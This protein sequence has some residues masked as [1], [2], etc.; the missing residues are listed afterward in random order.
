MRRA[1]FS[2][3]FLIVT[4][5]V[6]LG[7]VLDQFLQTYSPVPEVTQIE[8]D[9]LVVVEEYVRAVPP[10]QAQRAVQQLA[11]SLQSDI[12]LLPADDL[13]KSHLSRVIEGGDIAVVNTEEGDKLLYKAVP[14]VDQVLSLRRTK[15]ELTRPPI[16]DVLLIVFYGS[17]AVVVFFWVWPLSRDLRRLEKQTRLIGN[18]Q[19]PHPLQIGQRSTV[20]DLAQ[21]FNRMSQRVRELLASHKDMTNAVSHELRTPLAR[22]KFALEMAIHSQDPQRVNKELI[23][24]RQDVAEMDAL[25]NQLLSY[26]GFEQ[27]DQSLDFQKGDL[28]WLVTHM[29]TRL[30]QVASTSSVAI[31]VQDQ[32]AGASVVCE[33]HLMERA[34]LNLLQNA[35]RFAHSQIRVMFGR[36]EDSFWLTVED[37]GPGVKEEE[38]DK[39]FESFVRLANEHNGQTRGFGLGLAIVKRI[40]LW[41][42]GTA[43]V[44]TSALGGAR[45]VLQWPLLDID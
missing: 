9:L 29:V 21:S 45:F 42:G 32:L 23:G 11:S 8:R 24:I 25:V 30:R 5:V 37:D 13:A 14:G 27:K 7:W 12:L 40:L 22:M 1:F 34:I 17:I 39:V 28:V 36:E 4:A 26:A 2:L 38:R 10:D 43:F 19:L 35:Q 6:V 44:D 3:Y 31:T 18:D 20:Y 41:H 16:Y 33:W 15:T